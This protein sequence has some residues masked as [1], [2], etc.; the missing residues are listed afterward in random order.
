MKIFQFSRADIER[1][2]RYKTAREFAK[3][4]R[5]IGNKDYRWAY[6]YSLAK[7][8]RAIDQVAALD[9]KSEMIARY[10]G[11][12]SGML[13]IG[14]TLF[15]SSYKA[16]ADSIT[17]VHPLAIVAGGLVILLFLLSTWCAVRAT[18][19]NDIEIGPSVHSALNVVEDF[20]TT[21]ESLGYMS[22]AMHKA[23]VSVALTL[24]NKSKWLRVSH[25]FFASGLVLALVGVLLFFCQ[26]YFG[27][28]R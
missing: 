3:S 18:L 8:A 5:P 9:A 25:L 24:E 11:T 10:V 27:W 21:E 12:G 20:A 28:W 4:F 15:V 14:L 17:S 7:I 16:S 1:D 2:Q 23:F 19:T 6:D 26:L 22:A 13:G